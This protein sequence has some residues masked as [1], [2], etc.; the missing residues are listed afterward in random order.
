MKKL[1]ELNFKNTELVAFKMKLIL[2]TTII[3]EKN[4]NVKSA[5][6]KLEVNSEW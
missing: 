2:C 3:F 6:L 5:T 4:G 1:K